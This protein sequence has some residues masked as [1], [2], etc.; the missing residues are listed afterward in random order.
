LRSRCSVLRLFSGE[1]SAELVFD[2]SAPR[3]D[4]RPGLARLAV[5]L[6]YGVAFPVQPPGFASRFPVPEPSPERVVDQA[7]LSGLVF[8]FELM[9][10]EHLMSQIALHDVL[11]PDRG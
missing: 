9:E 4:G 8:E 6:G 3:P 2:G 7:M 1:P 10:V 5:C 11:C